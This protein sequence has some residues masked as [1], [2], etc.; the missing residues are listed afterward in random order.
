[1]KRNIPFE[2]TDTILLYTHV[3]YKLLHSSINKNVEVHIVASYFLTLVVF[4]DVE[5]PNLTIGICIC[6]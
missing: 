5:E 2:M 3:L 4:L 1:M 6:L